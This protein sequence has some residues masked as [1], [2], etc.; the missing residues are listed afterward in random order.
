MQNLYDMFMN[1]SILLY[2][3]FDK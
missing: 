3:Q 2:I 1:T